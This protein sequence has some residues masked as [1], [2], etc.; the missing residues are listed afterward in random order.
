MQRK[1]SRVSPLG[2]MQIPKRKSER[3]TSRNE[4]EVRIYE[5]EIYW[6]SIV[7]VYH[8]PNKKT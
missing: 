2:E 1:P 4:N 6:W 3:G 7:S 8:R 5:P